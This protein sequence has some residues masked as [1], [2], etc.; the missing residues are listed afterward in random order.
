MIQAATAAFRTLD[1]VM[2][3]LV[4]R[5]GPPRLSS[6]RTGQSRFEQ[7]AEAICYQQLAGRAAQAI[8]SRVRALVPGPFTA[9]A[10]LALTPEQLRAAGLSGAKTASILDLAVKVDSGVVRLDRIGR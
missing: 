7:L 1:P 5:Y 6:R 10:V 2:A 8:W 9:A 4:D 3:E